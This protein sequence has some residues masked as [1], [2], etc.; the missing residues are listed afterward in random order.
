MPLKMKTVR[1]MSC[2]ILQVVHLTCDGETAESID[3]VAIFIGDCETLAVAGAR[4]TLK[5]SRTFP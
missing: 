3:V 1:D 2:F 4:L 5:W